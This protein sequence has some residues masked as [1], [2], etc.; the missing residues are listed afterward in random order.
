MA[1]K[2][3]INQV[4]TAEGYDTLYPLT[5]YQVHQAQSVIGD[6]SN[7]AITIDLPAQY[8]TIPIIVSFTPNVSNRANCTISVNGLSSKPIYVNNVPA[9]SNAFGVNDVCLVQYNVNKN[10][11]H[12][13]GQS[14]TPLTGDR[15]S[16]TTIFDEDTITFTDV[17]GDTHLTVFNADGSITETLTR[18][19][20]ISTIN[21]YFNEDGSITE[22]I[23]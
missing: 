14:G 19:T 22:V 6:G 23:S 1:Q 13:V 18:G 9:L 7:Y 16:G 21:T 2:N 15:E 17:N 3:I 5:P 4:K 12:V 20:S 10:I 11:A 8:I